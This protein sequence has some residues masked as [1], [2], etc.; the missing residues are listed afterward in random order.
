MTSEL[1]VAT[2][3]SYGRR[4]QTGHVERA[5]RSALEKVGA[6]RAN[7]LLLFLTSDYAH[8]PLPAIRSAARIASCTQVSGA[9]GL[10]LLTE[11]QWV[12]DSSGAAAMAFT[13]HIGLESIQHAAPGRARLCLCTPQSVSADWLGE[14]I[15]RFGAISSDEYG[16]GP[17]AIWHSGA[18]AK[19][20]FME[21]TVRGASASIG[22]A[23]G[24][25]VLTAPMKVVKS[26]GSPMAMS[27]TS[28]TRRA[29]TSPQRDAGT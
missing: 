28:A 17:F 4:D 21:S 24:V 20:G 26:V 19:D 6:T 8:E 25:Q 11:E 27:P 1:Q 15:P 9:T 10:G 12:I 14:P 3:I 5:V 16:H 22:V 29:F 18:L 2:G 13:G 7:G 23:R